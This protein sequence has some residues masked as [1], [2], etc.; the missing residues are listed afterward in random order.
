ML[1]LCSK[2][3][4]V[5]RLEILKKPTVVSRI[6]SKDLAR[7]EEQRCSTRREQ[8]GGVYVL[9][10]PFPLGQASR[11]AVALSWLMNGRAPTPAL[12]RLSPALAPAAAVP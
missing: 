9:V 6:F 4:T 7:G 2:W 8:G 10:H 1:A 12:S 3:E 5:G 11:S